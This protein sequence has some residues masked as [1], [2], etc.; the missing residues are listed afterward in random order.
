[1]IGMEYEQETRDK[2]FS[3]NE[4]KRHHIAPW[5]SSLSHYRDP[6]TI[7]TMVLLARAQ[8]RLLR[9]KAPGAAAGGKFVAF[10]LLRDRVT[11]R[12]VYDF[13]SGQAI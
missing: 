1:M 3:A 11:M 9:Q 2:G 5:D 10:E 12:Q 6:T 7:E 8:L 4:L 13:D